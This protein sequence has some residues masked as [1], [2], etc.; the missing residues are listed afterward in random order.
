MKLL[1]TKPISLFFVCDEEK[2]STGWD[3]RR[4]DRKI[5]RERDRERER[6]KARKKHCTAQRRENADTQKDAGGRERGF[7]SPD[8]ANRGRSLQFLY[9]R[10]TNDPAGRTRPKPFIPSWGIFGGEQA[11]LSQPA[12]VR[13]TITPPPTHSH[14]QANSP[15]LGDILHL[16]LIDMMGLIMSA[17]LL[18][19]TS[20]ALVFAG[21]LLQER[22]SKL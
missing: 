14:I 10:A 12:L 19:G 18:S 20:W 13:R 11:R 3:V 4:R 22:A 6:Q 8:S 5:E 15:C 21:D 7:L 2:R 17:S 16:C 9:V 1:L